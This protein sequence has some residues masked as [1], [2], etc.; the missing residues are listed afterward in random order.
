MDIEGESKRIT[1]EES[2]DSFNHSLLIIDNSSFVQKGPKVL[3]EM[4]IC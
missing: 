2:S 3:N 1:S 4:M